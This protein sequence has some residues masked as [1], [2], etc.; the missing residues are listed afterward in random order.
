MSVTGDEEAITRFK[1]QA[2]KPYKTGWID[3][4][5]S[6]GEQEIG[7]HEGPLS[8]WN[9]ITPPEEKLMEYFETNGWANGVQTGQTEWN[10]YQWNSANWG[11]KWDAGDACLSDES[12]TSLDYTFETPWS[13][14]T[15]VFTAMVE[16]F[17]TLSFSFDSVEEQGWGA[18]FAG[19]QGELT[20]V[21][22][23]D[24]PNSHKEHEEHNQTCVCEW[25]DDEPDRWF[26]DCPDKAEALKKQKQE[27][28]EGNK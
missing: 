10:W 9:F 1:E 8:F 17:P 13:I 14:P 28:E 11:C 24:V 12:P 20:L 23:W 19:I 4:R 15:P 25:A 5:L 21:K 22:E 3:N 2:S 6:L 27:Q 16:Q 26:D 7:T 18:E